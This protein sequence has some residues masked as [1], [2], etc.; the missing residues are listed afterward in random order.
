[1][2]FRS[3]AAGT[4]EAPG[5]NVAQKS[6]LN[7]SIL[8]QGWGMADQF[9]RYKQAERGHIHDHA[10]A[11]Y[12]SLR[13]PKANCGHCSPN[14]R[15]TRDLFRCEVCGFEEHADIVGA[16]NVSQGRVLP[17]EPPKRIRKR[18]GKRKPLEGIKHAA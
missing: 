13:C 5:N 9:M 12:T 16:I 7:R 11:P 17:V 6:G 18:V 1:M 14:N 2:L 3:S 4:A 10:P 15:P 8:D